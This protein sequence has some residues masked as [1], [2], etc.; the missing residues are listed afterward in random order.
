[1]HRPIIV[2]L[3]RMFDRNLIFKSAINLKE[4]NDKRKSSK[5]INFNAYITDHLPEKFQ[6]YRKLLLPLYKEAKKTVWKALDG[7]YTLF[8]KNKNVDSTS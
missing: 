6:K 3:Q 2:K 5:N 7:N 4:Y 8:I 1:M